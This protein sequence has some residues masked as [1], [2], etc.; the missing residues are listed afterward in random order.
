VRLVDWDAGA[1]EDGGDEVRL[2]EGADERT[3]AIDDGM[4]NPANA[5]LI[6]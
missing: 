1:F 5:E 6:R 2:R 3:S 4:R